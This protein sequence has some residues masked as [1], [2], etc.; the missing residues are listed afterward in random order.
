MNPALNVLIAEIQIK[1]Q[2]NILKISTLFTYEN[3]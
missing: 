2:A 3:Y 1:C